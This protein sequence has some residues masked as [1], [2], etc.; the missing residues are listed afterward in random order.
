MD[1]L[2]WARYDVVRK[3]VQMLASSCE[4]CSL[5]L[6]GA[7]CWIPYAAQLSCTLCKPELSHGGRLCP[8]HLV[9][10]LRGYLTHKHSLHTH[11]HTHAMPAGVAW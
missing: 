8:V 11:A 3:V 1:T 10:T 4:H 7:A 9:L 5:N 6:F 2:T